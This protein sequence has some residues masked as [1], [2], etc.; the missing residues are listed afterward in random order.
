MFAFTVLPDSPFGPGPLKNWHHANCI[1][2]IKSK[3]GSQ[4]L[5]S[6]DLIEGYQLLS[7]THKD[8]ILEQ[9]NTCFPTASTTSVASGSSAKKSSSGVEEFAGKNYRADSKDNLFKEFRRIVV[10]M[11]NESSYLKKTQILNQFLIKVISNIYI[12]PNFL[13]KF[14]FRAQ[15]ESNL[16][17]ISLSG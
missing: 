15:T 11:T 17:E 8:F 6:I 9:I 5:D 13:I 7:E 16:R 4:V 1:F 2:E 14:I 10:N 12:N 3:K